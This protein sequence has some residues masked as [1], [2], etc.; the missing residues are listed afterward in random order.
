MPH[1]AED[2]APAPEVGLNGQGA[3]V[4]D[5]DSRRQPGQGAERAEAATPGFSI[6]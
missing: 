1:A 2:V 6:Q 4:L 5:A 3:P